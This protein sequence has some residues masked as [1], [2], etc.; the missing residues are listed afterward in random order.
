MQ[1]VMGLSRKEQ[2]ELF[3]QLRDYLGADLGEKSKADHAITERLG[4]LDA[5]ARVA[6]ELGLE[7]GQAP[8]TTQFRSAVGWV[9]PA[10]TVSRWS[11]PWAL[12]KRPGCLSRRPGA[13]VGS[14][15]DDP[16]PR[17]WEPGTPTKTKWPV[18]GN[19]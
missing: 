4:A 11:R 6:S 8:T 7:D 18:F 16:F 15:T 10:W 19:G 14:P 9:A 2:L 13:G 5:L 1:R 17:P 3:A 12:A